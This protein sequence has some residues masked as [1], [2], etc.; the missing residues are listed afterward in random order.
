M[1]GGA[2]EFDLSKARTVMARYLIC[3]FAW[4]SMSACQVARQET[5][6]HSIDSQLDSNSDNG[7]LNDTWSVQTA[8]RLAGLCTD[9]DHS[10]SNLELSQKEYPG[11]AMSE[12]AQG[13]V[14][15][16]TL[17]SQAGIARAMDAPEP[18]DD[19]S[20]VVGHTRYYFDKS[21]LL[22]GYSDLNR[23]NAS[24]SYYTVFV[25]AS[26]EMHCE[27]ING[28]VEVQQRDKTELQALRD[29]GHISEKVKIVRDLFQPF[30][31]LHFETPDI[32]ETGP[33]L[34]VAERLPLFRSSTL[35]DEAIDT[36]EY[37]EIV[38]YIDGTRQQVN[39]GKHK[40]IAYK[41]RTKQMDTGWVIGH[42]DMIF[43]PNDEHYIDVE[44]Q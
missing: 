30:T 31:P 24:S 13:Q 1:I 16:V 44:E 12:R 40:W 34:Q 10:I 11:W 37:G 5:P 15:R 32:S 4:V 22:I 14:P 42:P 36:L 28:R 29:G 33:E 25:S 39:D 3:L 17:Y 20:E 8:K 9:V 6:D 18:G 21:G 7:L 2:C 26:I 35:T 41:I 19:L 23:E 43:D 38:Y 27:I